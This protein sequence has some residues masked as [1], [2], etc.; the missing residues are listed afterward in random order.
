MAARYAGQTQ[1]QAEADILNWW[2]EQVQGSEW[3]DDVTEREMEFT[4]FR[5]RLLL[6]QAMADVWHETTRSASV[7]RMK[8]LAVEQHVRIKRNPLGQYI[9]GI[10]DAVL[11]D[12]EGLWIVDNKTTGKSP[13]IQSLGASFSL[14]VRLY[15]LLAEAAY[16]DR[17]ILGFIHNIIQKPT[18][19]LS[20]EDRPFEEVS[21][22]LKSGPRKGQVVTRKEFYG[23]PM[24]ENYVERVRDWYVGRG[25]YA[26]LGP[27]RVE[28]PALLESWTVLL[29]EREPPEL[30]VILTEVAKAGRANPDLN[31]YYRNCGSCVNLFD[32]CEFLPLCGSH[33]ATWK[34]LIQENYMPRRSGAERAT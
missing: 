23:E 6:A 14:E 34:P 30:S 13:R 26:H 18:I 20:A 1:E 28:N 15:R 31:R 5:Q 27:D 4:K 33:P 21:H 25:R 17:K 19:R 10:L 11:D 22:T 3:K 12:G 29:E 24:Y 7:D 32:T 8:V 2:D 16:P 9:H